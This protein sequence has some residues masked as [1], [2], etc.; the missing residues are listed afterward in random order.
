[1]KVCIVGA[2]VVGSYLAKKLSK[3]EFEV[4]VVDIDGTKLEAISHL[5]RIHI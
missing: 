4:I 2:G 1:L 3:E 5:S